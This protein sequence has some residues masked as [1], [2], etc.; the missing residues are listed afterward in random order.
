MSEIKEKLVEVK[1]YRRDLLC[2]ECGSVLK[3]DRS[4]LMSSPP[5]FPHSCSNKECKFEIYSGEYRRSGDL[6]HKE[7][8]GG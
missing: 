2:P 3:W 1:T 4:S 5:Q 6:I 7:V 8:E